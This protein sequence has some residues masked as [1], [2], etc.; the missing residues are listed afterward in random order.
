[1]DVNPLRGAQPCDPWH[2]T[3]N[4]NFHKWDQGRNFI[5]F[6]QQKLPKRQLPIHV[7]CTG[8][9]ER[10]SDGKLTPTYCWMLDSVNRFV[11]VIDDKLVFQRYQNGDV[12]MWGNIN[13]GNFNNCVDSNLITELQNK[14]NK[15]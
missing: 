2:Y 8:Y 7:G 11:A 3:G 12:L 4:V 1:M 13:H 15:L 14:I 6:C 9:I 10:N 5:T